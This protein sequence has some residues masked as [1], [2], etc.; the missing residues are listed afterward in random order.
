M[1]NLRPH[2][3]VVLLTGICKEPLSIIVE[4]MEGGSLFNYLRNLEIKISNEL[5]I[6]FIVGIARGMFHLHSEKIVHRDLASRNVLLT[7]SLIPK[8]SDFGMSRVN[9]EN[10]DANKTS[11]N[12][13][14]LKWMAPECISENK[15]S[16]KS[17]VWA[18]QQQ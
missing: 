2:E 6:L 13:G 1:K 3:N 9:L 16:N 4:Y 11:S 12:V 17:D 15:Y 14:P 7:K 10:E 18:F 8:I 5:Q